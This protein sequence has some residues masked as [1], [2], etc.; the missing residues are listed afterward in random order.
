[1]S[2]DEEVK[3]KLI[4]AVKFAHMAIKNDTQDGNMQKA[5][6]LYMNAVSLF[7]EVLP[8]LNDNLKSMLQERVSK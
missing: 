3:K 5:S 2:S 7:E 1:M 4:D 6:H 8:T